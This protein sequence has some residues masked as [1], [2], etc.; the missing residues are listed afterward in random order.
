M[1]NISSSDFIKEGIVKVKSKVLPSSASTNATYITHEGNITELY[2]AYDYLG[3]DFASRSSRENQDV[4]KKVKTVIDHIKENYDEDLITGLSKLGQKFGQRPGDKSL[5]D[6]L[7][8]GVKYAHESFNKKTS[9]EK[10]TTYKDQIRESAGKIE[11]LKGE[12]KAA[13]DQAREAK[14]LQKL[15]HKIQR[16][17]E[18]K[19]GYEAKVQQMI[20]SNP[21]LNER[22]P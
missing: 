5:I 22:K 19:K 20:E 18:R 7:Y 15:T 9:Q 6:H 2:S 10:V 8:H 21:I 3:L 17:E 13:M 14:E 1:E 16:Y 4:F 12:I 11:Q